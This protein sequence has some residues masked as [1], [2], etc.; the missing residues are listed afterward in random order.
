MT[1]IL[2]MDYINNVLVIPAI[3]KLAPVPAT[4]AAPVPPV[5]TSIPP[6]PALMD[7]SGK[8]GVVKKF[9]TEQQAM[10]I[11]V[12]VRLLAFVQQAWTSMLR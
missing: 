12:M 9:L 4:P 10:F 1:A 3:N 6:A 5:A 7:M 11:N 2:A 8:M